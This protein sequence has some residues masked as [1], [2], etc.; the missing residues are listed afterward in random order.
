M[1]YLTIED[2]CEMLSIS[3]RT[4]ERM[5]AKPIDLAS[6]IEELKRD[7]VR[8]YADHLTSLEYKED[9]K[10]IE[11]GEKVPFP[12]PEFYMGKSPRWEQGKLI[13]WLKENGNKL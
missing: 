7:G 6:M 5:R 8:E 1:K 12:E 9:Q 2:V 4:L 11:S 13:E 3:R 10:K